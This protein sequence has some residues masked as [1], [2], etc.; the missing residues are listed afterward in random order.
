[1][2]IT[3]SPKQTITMTPDLKQPEKKI[4]KIIP[5]NTCIEVD[6]KEAILEDLLAAPLSWQNKPLTNYNFNVLMLL[7]V[8]CSLTKTLRPSISSLSARVRTPP[9]PPKP[10]G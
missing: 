3:V 7:A 4:T 5:K 10:R 2:K 9:K 1:M 8:R 6:S